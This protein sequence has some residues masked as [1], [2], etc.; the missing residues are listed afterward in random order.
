[1]NVISEVPN[2]VPTDFAISGKN[3]DTQDPQRPQIRLMPNPAASMDSQII[4]ASSLTVTLDELSDKRI[5]FGR[6]AQE[7]PGVNVDPSSVN[8]TVINNTISRL[9]GEVFF[10]PD[11]HNGQWLWRDHS[12]NGT[13]FYGPKV[14]EYEE[15]RLNYSQAGKINK[16]TVLPVRISQ[17]T[18]LKLGGDMAGTKDSA[19]FLRVHFP[20]YS[21]DRNSLP[22]PTTDEKIIV[23]ERIPSLDAPMDPE[24]EKIVRRYSP[25]VV[26]PPQEI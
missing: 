10:Q 2:P 17:G 13:T 21:S 3:Y 12:S 11:A 7:T 8:K 24:T 4:Q 5:F 23:I 6:E 18:V 16:T 26:E 22:R 20:N 19:V 25:K 1:M 9:H 15:N 14:L